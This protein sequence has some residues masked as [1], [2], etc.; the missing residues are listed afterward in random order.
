M[1]PSPTAGIELEMR[2]SLGEDLVKLTDF[3]D[4][5]KLEKNLEG[6]ATVVAPARLRPAGAVTGTEWT[7]DLDCDVDESVA[8]PA[9]TT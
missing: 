8:S 1:A 9:R 6:C 2:D 3:R 4:D 7:W 5:A